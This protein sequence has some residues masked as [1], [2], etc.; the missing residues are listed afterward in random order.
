MTVYAVVNVGGA[1]IDFAAG[2]YNF[3]PGYY[4]TDGT[5]LHSGS[6]QIFPSL[7]T[8]QKKIETMIRDGV[9]AAI[10]SDWSLVIDPD[11]L[12]LVGL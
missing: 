11:D 2:H 9:A 7:G 6:P 3:Q 1:G 12:I 5:V 4:V 8:S 10:L